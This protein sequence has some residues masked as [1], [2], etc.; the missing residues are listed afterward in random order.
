MVYA[1][2]ETKL[3]VCEALVIQAEVLA[4]DSKVHICAI[5]AALN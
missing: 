3:G 4:I 2:L 1:I 5:F